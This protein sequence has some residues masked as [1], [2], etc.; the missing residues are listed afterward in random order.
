MAYFKIEFSNEYCRCDEVEYIEADT[1]GDAD[2]YASEALSEYGELV[3]HCAEGFS[4]SD[5]WED[6]EAEANY[7]DGIGYYV[8]EITKKEY[9]AKDE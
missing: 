6:E 2:V 9:D 4:F 8:T 7:Y 5:G 3:C 1:F